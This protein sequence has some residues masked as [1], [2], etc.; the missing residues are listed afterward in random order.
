M[1]Q[2]A[3]DHIWSQNTLNIQQH[4]VLL[5]SNVINS[6]YPITQHHHKDSG[7]LHLAGASSAV[8]QYIFS[9]AYNTLCDAMKTCSDVKL[10]K[11]LGE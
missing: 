10:P 8:R 4:V 7:V 2:H 6:R 5:A 9:T 11:Q 3:F 1:D